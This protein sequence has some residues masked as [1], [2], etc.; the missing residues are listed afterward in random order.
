MV[1]GHVY[2]FNIFERQTKVSM[3]KKRKT[4]HQEQNGTE[5][6]DLFRIIKNVL[7]W[8]LSIFLCIYIFDSIIVKGYYREYILRKDGV[9]AYAH[10]S[11]IKH[12]RLGHQGNTTHIVYSF[13]VDGLPYEGE[14]PFD[15]LRVGDSLQIVY[16]RDNPRINMTNTRVKLDCHE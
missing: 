2:Y 6:F 5:T 11:S 14:S 9:C 3:K 10:V 7:G 8:G 12:I 1:E 16:L 15:N 4:Y 13:R